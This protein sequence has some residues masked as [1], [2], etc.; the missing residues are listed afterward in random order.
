MKIAIQTPRWALPILTDD[1]RYLFLKGG[2]GSGKSHF[3][4][5]Y[6]IEQFLLNPNFRLVCIREIQ[7]S[8]KFSSKQLLED[9]IKLLG[10]EHLF[11][12]TINEIRFLNGD[13]II[14]F[15]G[16]QDHTAESIK[17]LEGF[18]GAWVEE[19]QS[20]SHR[21]LQLLRPTI[22][23][24]GSK[25]AFTWNPRKETDAV[26]YFAMQE[27]PT[28]SLTIH[29]NYHDNP[30]LPETLRYEAEEDQRRDPE[31]Y[32][33]V[34]LGGYDT[35]SE[36]QI[37]NKRWKVEEFEVNY[38]FGH[39]M[40]G[41]DFGFS[42]DSLACVRMYIMNNKLY[43]SHEAGDTHIELNEIAEFLGKGIPDLAKYVIFAD[44][45]RPDSI[46][47]LKKH[48]LPMIAP[49]EKWSG[50]VEDGISYIKSFD[51]VI[52]HPRC[53]RTIEEFQNYEYKIDRNTGQ[54]TSDIID[55]WNH[56]IDSI[57]YGL[58][59]VIRKGSSEPTNYAKLI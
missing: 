48:G 14:I 11:E 2:R 23:K 16:M 41:L 33:H 7:R 36:A 27:K 32:A 56:F 12:S 29:I 45:S 38:K 58:Y 42:T 13:G 1:W 25:I 21:S 15:Q 10:V 57:R 51:E 44:C 3:I 26:D 34:W 54:V 19:A 39:P 4:S 8:L 31:V 20:L 35:K 5:E 28:K 30:F 49:C 17:S 52:I 37:F 43:I 24:Q 18:D 47:Y 55:A 9:K 46:S 22:R 40:H 53:K 6:W 59:K 50:S